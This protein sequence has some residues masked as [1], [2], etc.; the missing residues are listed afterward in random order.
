MLLL[1]V[2]V[3]QHRSQPALTGHEQDPRGG[4]LLLV[5][6]GTCNGNMK[7]QAEQKVA[8]VSMK[9]FVK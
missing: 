8:D 2:F 7:T 4:H 3:F 5:R 9:G 6:P 1:S